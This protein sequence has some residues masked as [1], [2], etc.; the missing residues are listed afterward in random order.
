[1]HIV[2]AATEHMFV[3]AMEERVMRC[4]SPSPSLVSLL[5][6]GCVVILGCLRLED[7]HNG[8]IALAAHVLAY[9]V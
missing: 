2:A 3:F 4:G 6:V 9:E 8:P 7:M 5:V 1:M